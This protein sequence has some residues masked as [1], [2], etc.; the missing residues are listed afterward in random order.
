MG[1][2]QQHPL[3]QHQVRQAKECVE[4][5]R[6]LFESSVSHL[7]M[8]EQ[9]LHHMEGV[10][11]LRPY[12][13]FELLDPA[14]HFLD[15]P[16]CHP[17]DLA[18]LER[19]IPRP[20]A[21]FSRRL[22]LL[23]NSGVTRVPVARRLLSMQKV[24]G[25]FDVPHIG[26]RPNKRMHQ[27]RLGVG[28]NMGFHPKV[29]H[30]A[31]LGLVHLRVALLAR[32]LGRGGRRDDGGI[33]NGA[34]SHQQVALAQVGVDLLEDSLG[35]SMPF[36]QVPELQKRGGIGHGFHPKVDPGKAAHRLA[37]VESV[38]E[39]LIGQRIP[40]LQKIH[41]Q[42]PLDP[43]GLAPTFSLEVMRLDAGNQSRPRHHHLHF[44]QKPLPA[45]GLFL[46]C[47]FGLGEAFL[48]FH[49]ARQ[50]YH[51]PRSKP[52][53]NQRFLRGYWRDLLQSQPNHIEIV[54]E[55]NTIQSTIEPVAASF[56]IPLTIGR[57]Y[58]S[59]SPKHQIA[60]RY[61][62]SGK[63]KLILLIISDLDP[64]GEEIA[65]SLARSLRDDFHV[66]R[67]EALKVALKGS[68]VVDL[69]LPASMVIAKRTSAN[70][71]RF[72]REQ[73]TDRVY[74]L[75]ALEPQTLRQLLREAIESVLD[76]EAFN[77]EQQTLSDDAVQIEAVRQRVLAALRESGIEET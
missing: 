67:I 55:K 60:S 65:H 22:F 31:F 36:Q 32:V 74:E 75:E 24:P 2:G 6:V 39:R 52:S 42:H 61:R 40:L 11:D 63:Q 19:H 25:A 7:A 59:T 26:C 3:D 66:H 37:V 33:D 53:F 69:G 64:D 38:F 4:L 71:A 51:L 62:D 44:V 15:L 34:F 17:L 48:S 12:L 50:Y 5:R 16:L 30:V 49:F 43:Y 58:C 10:L 70:Y 72:V 14:G 28:S 47:V 29:P 21:G 35:Q 1:L 18:A 68:Q 54:G 46:L 56:G 77:A 23:F 8:P 20:L 27:P 73:C 9:V 13:R 57:G 45:G 76:I 41:P